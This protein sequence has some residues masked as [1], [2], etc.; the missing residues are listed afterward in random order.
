MKPFG[1]GL[2]AL[3]EKWSR[4]Q[5]DSR[6]LRFCGPGTHAVETLEGRADYVDG[7]GHF[8]IGYES[9]TQ[10]SLDKDRPVFGLGCLISGFPIHPGERYAGRKDDNF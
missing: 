8:C 3:M 2:K 6:Q 7:I 9:L 1:R 10:G 4:G 5:G